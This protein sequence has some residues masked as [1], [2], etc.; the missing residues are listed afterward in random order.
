MAGKRFRDLSIV[1]LDAHN[2]LVIAC[3][4]SAGIGEK[5]L[6]TVLIDPAITAAYSARVPL[7]EL[8]CFGADSLTVVDTIGNEMTP[9]A[10]RVIL[11]IQRELEK[12]GVAD[13]PLNGSTEDNM[14]T[15]T[16]SIGVTVIGKAHQNNAATTKATGVLLVYQ[17]GKPYVGEE[18][19][20]H[21][22]TIFSYDLVRKIRRNK[23]VVDMLPVGSRGVRYEMV[24]MAETH[25]AKIEEVADLGTADKNQS[26]GPATVILVAIIESKQKQFEQAFP[27]MTLLA[28][29]RV[30]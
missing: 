25:R 14:P 29:L 23:A 1:E 7:L 5:E 4:C 18:V 19:K 22:A 20:K 28:K 16:T 21:L 17:L 9:T 2:T 24:Q 3:D 15:K 26:A 11:G 12:A 8:L 27:K 10:D 13:I 6:D 30:S